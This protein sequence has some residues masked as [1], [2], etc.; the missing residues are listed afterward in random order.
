[1]RSPDAMIG[2]NLRS[3]PAPKGPSI[4]YSISTNNISVS[5]STKSQCR[6]LPYRLHHDGL[7]ELRSRLLKSDARN[8]LPSRIAHL[9]GHETSHLRDFI[10]FQPFAVSAAFSWPVFPPST[11]GEYDHLCIGRLF[12]ALINPSSATERQYGVIRSYC[13][14]IA[15][16]RIINSYPNLWYV[17]HHMLAEQ[18]HAVETLP[19]MSVWLGVVTDYRVRHLATA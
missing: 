18:R 8:K 7:R 6:Y 13:C 15:L 1:M 12:D 4:R 14:I 10:R 9:V 16:C 17:H 3:W 19:T 5:G 11:S 2:D